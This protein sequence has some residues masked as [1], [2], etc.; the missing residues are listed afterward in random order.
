MGGCGQVFGVQVPPLVH[1]PPAVHADWIPKVHAPVCAM[2]HVPI[3][4]CGQGFGL[5]FAPCV[6]YAEPVAQLICVTAVHPPVVVLQQ[7]PST[8]CGQG[9]VGV[10]VRALRPGHRS[11]RCI[12]T[13][14]RACTRP[15]ERYSTCCWAE[16]S[17]DSGCTRR[18]WSTCWAK[19]SS[20]GSWSST[21]QAACST[22]PRGVAG[23]D[24][25]E[26]KKAA[27]RPDRS[28]VPAD[29]LDLG[30][31]HARARAGV[32][33]R[34]AWRDRARIRIA[35]RPTGPDAR[36]RAV[37]L[38]RD[39]ADA[40]LRAARAGGGLRARIR[41]ADRAIRPD[42]RR[43]AVGLARH[44]ARAQGGAARSLRRQAR[45]R[46]PTGSIGRPHVRGHAKRLEIHHAPTQG[47]AADASL[48]WTGVRRAGVAGNEEIR[49]R[50]GARRARGA[51]SVGR[52][53][54]AGLRVGG[55]AAGEHADQSYEQNTQ[56]GRWRSEH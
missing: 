5:Q 54:R 39:G 18:R 17:R 41:I 43:R 10:Q 28:L 52:A 16:R 37:H 55:P 9:F 30:L 42:I 47:R 2:Q 12:G 8:G 20:P 53:A 21:R 50:A 36:R 35:D 3:G 6:H 51:S 32:A 25:S 44:A 48:A 22:R 4:G 26:S 1:T 45:V 11:R 46:R 40:K 29:A 38:D 24:W 23:R 49:E 19:R 7:L 33:A 34:A 31:L 13:G 14:R 15:S 27:L 56:N